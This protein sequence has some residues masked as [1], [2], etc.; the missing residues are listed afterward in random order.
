MGIGHGKDG[1]NGE[2]D[3]PNYDVQGVCGGY[4]TPNST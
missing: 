1:A 3:T 4:C 2:Y